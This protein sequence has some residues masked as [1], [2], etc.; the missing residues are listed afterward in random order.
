MRA[1][2]LGWGVYS[3]TSFLLFLILF[4]ISYLCDIKQIPKEAHK[5]ENETLYYKFFSK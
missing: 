3:L 2:I 1:N 5:K 4:F